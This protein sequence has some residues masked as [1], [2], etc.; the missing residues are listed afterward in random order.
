MK[1]IKE[2]FLT[3]ALIGDRVLEIGISAE[4]SGNDRKNYE[5]FL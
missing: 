1:A 2:D 4:S 5:I 3:L